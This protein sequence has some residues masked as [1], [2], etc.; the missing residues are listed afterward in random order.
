[1]KSTGSARRRPLARVLA[2]T[3]SALLI[4]A[5]CGAESDRAKGPT[6]GESRPNELF[7]FRTTAHKSLDPVKQFDQASAEIVNN[8]YDT[9]LT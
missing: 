2:S 3:L 6:A 5:S 1:M 7:L 9:L 4:L 8:V